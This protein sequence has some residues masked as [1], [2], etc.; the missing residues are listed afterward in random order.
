[1]IVFRGGYHGSVL[2]FATGIATN[3]VDPGDWI[4]CQYNDVA[5]VER[6]FKQHEDIAAII[7]EGMQGSGG[8]IQGS[9]EFL[10]AVRQCSIKVH[11]TNPCNAQSFH[12][13]L[14]IFAL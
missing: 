10:K 12:R 1:M 9:P 5:G 11:S 8:A 4:V 6:A 14:T 2:S 3:N 7:L 13:L